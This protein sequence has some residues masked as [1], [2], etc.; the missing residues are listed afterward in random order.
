MSEPFF[1]FH[2]LSP[3][4]HGNTRPQ[5][6]PLAAVR[7]FIGILSLTLLMAFVFLNTMGKGSLASLP[8]N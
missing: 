7:A 6:F 8:H 5:G 4:G 3:S 1:C 2:P